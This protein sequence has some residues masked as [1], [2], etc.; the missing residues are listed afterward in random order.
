MLRW[1][2]FLREKLFILCGGSCTI[3]E[4]ISDI[5]YIFLEFFVEA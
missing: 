2:F 5:R 4:N 1:G 3:K